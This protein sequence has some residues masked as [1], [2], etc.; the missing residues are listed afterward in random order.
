MNLSGQTTTLGF[1]LASAGGFFAFL[2]P[3]IGWIGVAL[4]GSDTS[5]NSLFGLMQATAAEQ[6]GLSARC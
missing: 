6:T 4:T 1:A 3:L 5:S 2:S